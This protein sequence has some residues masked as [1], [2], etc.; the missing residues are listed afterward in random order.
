MSD[1]PGPTGSVKAIRSA[2]KADGQL[3]V[4]LD[5]NENVR[6]RSFTAGP[7][8]T[9]GDRL[10][11]DLQRSS[12]PQTVKR[13]SESYKPGR[14]IVV[15]IDAGHGGHDPGA[16]GK[17]RTREKDVAT[18][19]FKETRGTYQCRARYASGTHTQ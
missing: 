19:D 3:R 14:D 11:I 13:A 16:I 2:I 17:G 7:N 12:N 4:V 6:S 8:N 10:V 1:L 18:G 15:A 5:L 9:Y